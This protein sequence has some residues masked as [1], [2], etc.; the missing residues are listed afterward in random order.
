MFRSEA[1]RTLEPALEYGFALPT[2]WIT[3]ASLDPIWMEAE[4]KRQ[5]A[6]WSSETA[7]EDRQVGQATSPGWL[8]MV[9]K[10]MGMTNLP[11]VFPHVGSKQRLLSTT[12]PCP[13]DG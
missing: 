6:P 5:V 4:P 1:N 10:I 13:T 11:A 12:I 7:N 8:L 9:F 3:A 2:S